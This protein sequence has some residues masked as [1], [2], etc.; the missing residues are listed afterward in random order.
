MLNVIRILQTRVERAGNQKE[1][2]KELGISPQYL[3][4]L[5]KG[6]RPFSDKMLEKLGLMT[7]VVRL[8]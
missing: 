3:N 6:R 4:D 2:A 1:A 7:R 8:R 5:L